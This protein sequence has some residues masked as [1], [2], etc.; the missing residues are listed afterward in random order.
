[1]FACAAEISDIGD[2]AD[3]VCSAL[4]GQGEPSRVRRLIPE[5]CGMPWRS[6]IRVCL[7]S[8]AAALIW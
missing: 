6:P 7:S 2:R 4:T 8:A 5:R 3:G 1:M